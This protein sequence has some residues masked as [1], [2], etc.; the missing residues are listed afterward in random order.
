[1]LPHPAET[2]L[3]VEQAQLLNYVVHDQ[4]DVNLRLISHTFLVCLTQLTNL[5]DVESLIWVQLK[6]AHDYSA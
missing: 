5:S 2:S 4:V 1:M 3:V 6:H